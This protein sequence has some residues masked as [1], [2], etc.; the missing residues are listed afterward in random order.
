[1]YRSNILRPKKK[2]K[3][4]Q[5]KTK[6]LKPLASQVPKD[7]SQLIF[8]FSQKKKVSSITTSLSHA[9]MQV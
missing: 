2:L 5:N 6:K 8:K 4:K 3:K 1:M 9:I 7:E